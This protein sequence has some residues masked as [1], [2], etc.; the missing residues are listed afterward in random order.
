MAIFAKKI[1]PTALKSSQIGEISPY[2]VTLKVYRSM[3]TYTISLKTTT[4]LKTN[5]NRMVGQEQRSE[6]EMGT[7]D[8]AQLA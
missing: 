8:E 6:P 1:S 5:L 3:L 2:L 4:S 7:A